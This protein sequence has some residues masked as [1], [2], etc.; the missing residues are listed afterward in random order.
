MHNE[1]IIQ[2]SRTEKEKVSHTCQSVGVARNMKQSNVEAEK[3]GKNRQ[4]KKLMFESFSSA[5]GDPV[6]KK[7]QAHRDQFF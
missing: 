2:S 6:R 3:M 5:T 7:R 1:R 4:S